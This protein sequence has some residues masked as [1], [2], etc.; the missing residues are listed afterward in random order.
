V[1][2]INR[3]KKIK[4]GG[5]VWEREAGSRDQLG[6]RFL[7]PGWTDHWW[8]FLKVQTCLPFEILFQVG[9]IR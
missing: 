4:L 8:S 6:K 1:I 5:R 9:E 2:K 7:N 3:F